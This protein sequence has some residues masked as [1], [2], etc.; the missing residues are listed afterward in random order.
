MA[1]YY[2]Y[3][4]FPVYTDIIRPSFHEHHA[5]APLAHTRQAIAKAWHH[6]HDPETRIPKVDIRETKTKI[7]IDVELPGLNSKKDINMIWTN[8]S[9]LMC[10]ARLSRPVLPEEQQE[11]DEIATKDKTDDKKDTEATGHASHLTIGERTFGTFARAFDFPVEVDHETLDVV[12]Q[13]GLLRIIVTKKIA[14]EG[15]K[16]EQHE[17][18]IKHADEIVIQD[19]GPLLGGV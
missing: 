16:P 12:L 15:F 6:A 4:T 9:R 7:Y 10:K 8:A 17:V 18:Q 13:A 2:P 14:T 19:G 11:L 1:Y 3:Y 5:H